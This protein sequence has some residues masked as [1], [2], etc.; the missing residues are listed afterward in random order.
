[1]K[2]DEKNMAGQD[3]ETNPDGNLVDYKTA[4]QKRVKKAGEKI[5][6]K[7]AAKGK[8]A[9]GGGK[10]GRG[11]GGK[12]GGAGGGTAGSGMAGAGGEDL[13]SEFIMACLS[14]NELGDGELFKRLFRDH[15]VFNKSMDCWMVW[16]G[17]HWQVDKMNAAAASVEA[18]ARVYQDE[19]RRISGQIN[20]LTAEEDQDKHRGRIQDLKS[21]RAAL[22]KRAGALRS[23]R[24]RKNCLAFAH[25]SDEPL[26]IEGNEVD[27]RP[28]LLPCPNGVINLQT[29]E[30]EPGRQSDYLIK[31]CSVEW[32]A[33]GIKA[34]YEDWEVVL[35]EVFSGNENLVEFL[36]RICGYALIG[37]V[38]ESI[39]VVLHGQGRNGKSMIVE[40]ISKVMGPLAGAIRSEMLL[41]Q[42]RVASPSGPT[43]E[44]MSLRGLRMAFASETDDGCRLS[45]SKTKWLTGNDTLTGRNPHDKYDQQFPPSH[46]LFLLTNHKPRISAEDFAMWERML[47]FPFELSFVNRDPS[48]NK[49]NERRA[50]RG[51]PE[52]LE[53]MGPQILAWMVAGCLKY[54]KDGLQPPQ[55]VKDAVKEYRKN[56]DN[57]GD[58]I[59]Q[60]CVTGP[61]YKAGASDLYAK[62]EQWWAKNVSKNV[63]KQ[64]AFGTWLGKRF[65]KNTSG[66]V[67]YLGIGLLS[68]LEDPEDQGGT[69]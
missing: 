65:E 50:D 19:A 66:T 1:M 35:D 68:D 10:T 64:K 54:Q 7:K 53:K 45:T 41:D 61:D 18:V 63:P 44:I 36:Q 8:R 38:A 26:A 17:H 69:V 6:E 29:G 52:R 47:L 3:G 60:C 49:P 55:V 2:E 16:A 48:P 42:Q 21:A 11:G 34:D 30:L 32:P 24:R 37:K 62:F 40:T 33:E 51:L 59:E 14:R 31:A 58:F 15:F 56:E 13:D 46:T 57:L 12:G 67:T 5:R 22:N 9:A 23:T 20:K 25:T 27:Q 28:Y 4:V 39:L 43:P